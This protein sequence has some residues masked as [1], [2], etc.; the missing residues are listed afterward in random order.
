MV[1]STEEVTAT[2]PFTIRRRVRFGDCDPAGVVYTVRFSDYAVSA[3]DLFLAEMLGGPHIASARA[4][5]IDL[6]LKAL[7][8][9]FLSS[10]RPDDE[11]D[12]VVGVGAVRNSTFD[13]IVTASTP[14]GEPVFEAVITPICIPAGGERRSIEIPAAL[15]AKLTAVMNA[16]T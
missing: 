12:M 14:A 9:V 16:G 6:P 2:E 8:F 4:L 13:L 3:M 10:L 15:R 5:G 7:R 1:K 11:F